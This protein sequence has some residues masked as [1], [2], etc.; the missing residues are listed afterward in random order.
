MTSNTRSTILR[1]TSIKKVKENNLE[2]KVA[3]KELNSILEHYIKLLNHYVL[4]NLYADNGNVIWY[5]K[6]VKRKIANRQKFNQLLSE[7]C[8]D[9]YPDTPIFKNELINKTKISGQI[10]TARKNL[11]DQLLEDLDKENIGFDCAKFPPEKS[12][13]L[14]LLRETGIHQIN[15]GLGTMERP[16]DA[17]L[18]AL[19]DAGIAFLHS[20]KDKERNLTEFISV[21]SNRPF[22]LKQG[23]IDFWLPI[24]LLAKCHDFALFESDSYIPEITDDI[25]DLVN[26]RPGMFYVKAFDVVGI[27]LKLFNRYRVFLNQSENQQPNNKAFIQTIKP[28][29]AFYRELTEYSKNTNR[30]D[31][32][33]MA[34][35]HVIANA[36]DPEKAFFEDFPTALGYSISE[37]QNKPDKAEAFIKNLQKAIRELRTSYDGLLDRYESYFINE[38]I[39]IKSGFPA[40]KEV[41]NKRYMGLKAH[42]LLPN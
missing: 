29:L 40:Y 37:L 38:V 34:L 28:F 11:V 8:E 3:Q 31:K 13:Y 17:S 9:V 19:W 26:K 32:K 5:Y 36:K 23:F 21:L 24:F 27:K 20:T 4:D 6:G 35:R 18:H 7:V 39:G 2:D 25:L 33:T 15:D 16:T 12:I 30:L 41:I 14:T 22:K 42:L 1:K 10:S